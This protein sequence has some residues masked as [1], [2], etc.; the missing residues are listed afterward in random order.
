M[1]IS[2]AINLLKNLVKTSTSLDEFN[3]LD[4]SIAQAHERSRYQKAM[5]V[6]GVAIKAGE[7]DQVE[8]ERQVGL[9]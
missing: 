4:L 5:Q 6:V 7:L 9:K 3:H 8:F 2:D 1:E